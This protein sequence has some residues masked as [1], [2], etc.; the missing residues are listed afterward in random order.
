MVHVLQLKK[1]LNDKNFK[2]W[3][4]INMNALVGCSPRLHRFNECSFGFFGVVRGLHPT[5]L[6]KNQ[7]H[8]NMPYFLNLLFF[9]VKITKNTKRL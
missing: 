2:N 8:D 7:K 6:Y 1:K 5:G 9:N 4:G 3:L